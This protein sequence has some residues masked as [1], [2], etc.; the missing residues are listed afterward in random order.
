MRKPRID[1]DG[2]TAYQRLKALSPEEHE[3]IMGQLEELSQAKVIAQI[4]ARHGIR[5][6]TPARLSDFSAR[7]YPEQREIRAA[8]DTVSNIREIFEEVMPGA[9]R[10]ETHKFLVRFLAGTGF[11]QKDYKLL[12][13]ATVEERKA[14][15]IER[16]REK[17]EFDAA[18]AALKCLPQLKALAADK[19]L[20]E[21]ARLNAARKHLFGVVPK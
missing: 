8:N 15:E 14:I 5:G 11:G 21:P 20:D 3:A 7:W 12:Q 6:L 2:Q 19:A 1:A 18:R 16:E 17:F 10:L 9:G 4:E 13:F